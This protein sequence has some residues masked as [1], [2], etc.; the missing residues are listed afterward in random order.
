MPSLM[1]HLV[2]RR[3]MVHK[4]RN[5]ARRQVL[6]TFDDGPHPEITPQVLDRLD[7]YNAKAIF[8]VVGDRIKRGPE[9]LKAI[10]DR[11][12]WI[13]NHTYAHTTDRALSYK[14]YLSELRKC[15]EL[16]LE[17][18][19]IKP[20]FH[21]PPQGLITPATIFS[22]RQLKLTTIMWSLSSEDWRLKTETAAI[23]T[24][25]QLRHNV[26]HRDILLFHDER[27][28]TLTILDELLPRLKELQFDLAPEVSAIH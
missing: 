2:P 18:T 1:R 25:E 27:S 19:G 21:R 17:K 10:T 4:L 9:I 14:E 13:G 26:K 8:F 5:S 3:L 22:P 20:V 12:H 24:A 23:E 11:G 15:E 7:K 6:L 28:P 16:V